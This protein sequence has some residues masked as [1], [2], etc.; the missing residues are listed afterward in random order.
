MSLLLLLISFLGIF[1]LKLISGVTK[2]ICFPISII[3]TSRSPCSPTSENESCNIDVHNTTS[4]NSI[5]RNLVANN[6]WTLYFADQNMH[7]DFG[8]GCIFTNPC[9]KKNIISCR[10]EFECTNNIVEYEVFVFE[11]KKAID[12][13][14]DILKVIGDSEV[15]T[16]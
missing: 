13:K 14:V 6:I 1:F 15:V 5:G 9:N 7:D 10:L 2:H 11:L 8:V 16:H 12:L 3:Y 4:N